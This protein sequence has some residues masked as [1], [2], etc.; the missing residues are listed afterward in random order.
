MLA[1]ATF[2]PSRVGLLIF[3]YSGSAL[4]WWSFG[5]KTNRSRLHHLTFCHLDTLIGPELDSRH[6]A[7]G[8]RCRVG[9]VYS[10]SLPPCG[11]Y[12]RSPW[13]NESHSISHTRAHTSFLSS[14]PSVHPLTHPPN[15]TGTATRLQL[16]RIRIPRS[17]IHRILSPRYGTMCRVAM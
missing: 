17:H 2:V 5:S 6:P 1:W 8:A 3:L 14:V 11:L 15:R 13:L 12:C 16:K 7:L 4:L 9:V 10:P